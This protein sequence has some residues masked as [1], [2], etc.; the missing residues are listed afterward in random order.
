M[1]PRSALLVLLGGITPTTLRAQEPTRPISILDSV[2]TAEQADRGEETFMKVC[3]DCHLP[4]E[5]STAGYLASWE[6][7]R[8]SDLMEFVQA[9]MPEDNPASLKDTEYLDVMTYIL[10]L[11]GIPAGSR[12]LD[13]ALATKARIALP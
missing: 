13:I 3:I 11:N 5:F 6:G 7:Q 8:V 2:F 10:K 1:R 12:N 4:E 9:N